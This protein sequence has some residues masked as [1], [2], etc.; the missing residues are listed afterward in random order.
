VVGQQRTGPVLSLPGDLLSVTARDL[1][2]AGVAQMQAP[3]HD[4]ARSQSL[5]CMVQQTVKVG[6]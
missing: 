5:S 6:S 4:I 3:L 2:C 1:Q